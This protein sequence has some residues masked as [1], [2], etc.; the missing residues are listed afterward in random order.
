MRQLVVRVGVNR[1]SRMTTSSLIVVGVVGFVQG[2]VAFATTV[3][4]APRL[5][6]IVTALARK[7]FDPLSTGSESVISGWITRAICFLALVV[8]HIVVLEVVLGALSQHE[9]STRIYFGKIWVFSLIAGIALSRLLP[10]IEARIW[11]RKRK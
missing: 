10:E 8:L 1:V 9:P 4:L 5:A 3:G 6:A 7:P 2:F 11:F